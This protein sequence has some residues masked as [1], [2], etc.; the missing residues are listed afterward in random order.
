MYEEVNR[1]SHPRNTT[2][3]LSIPYTDSGRHTAL[4]HRQTDKQTPILVDQYKLIIL[5]SYWHHSTIG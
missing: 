5:I 2:V 4:R 1:K 3:Q